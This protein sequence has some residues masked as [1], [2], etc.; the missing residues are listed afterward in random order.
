MVLH[1][2]DCVDVLKVLFHEYDFLFLFDNSCGHDRQKDNG[3][4]V[5]RMR[6]WFGGSQKNLHNTIIRKEA[7]Y[8]G[9]FS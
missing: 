9:P 8:L 5:K 1:L 3:L 4:N 7:G 6:K 2:E